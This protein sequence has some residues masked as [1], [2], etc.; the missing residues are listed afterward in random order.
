M[1]CST[2]NRL[3][4]T[5]T[6]NG[7]T[8]FALTKA[9]NNGSLRTV[10][11][12]TKGR[13]KTRPGM[14]WLGSGVQG[15]VYLASFDK[16]NKKKVIIKV[17]PTDKNFKPKKQPAEIEYKI[18]TALYKVAPRHIP[19][20]LGFVRCDD[21]IP[22]SVF[23]KANRRIFN[24]KKQM[25][26]YSEYAH[27]GTLKDWLRKM[28]GR[29]TDTVM[30]D[31]VRQIVATLKKIQTRYPAFRHND[32][33]LGNILVDDTGKKPRLM[34]AD[35]G[36][37]RLSATM[38]SPIV[39]KENFRNVGI[40]PRTTSKYDLHYF[41]NALDFE[42][43]SGLPETKAFIDRMLPGPY[44]GLNSEYVLSLIHI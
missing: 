40:T 3:F 9:A 26:M 7:R 24:Y 30:A 25:I 44:R 37:S 2:R 23:I 31:L 34:L 18:Q 1:N 13:T 12:I 16:G 10:Y 38:S 41:L 6:N 42:I 17:S 14:A 19:K 27:G 39:N 5:A 29:V 28:G 32:L 4:Q 20:T 21:F 33:H 43:K 11:N 22:E 36:L 35:F 15:V 8:G